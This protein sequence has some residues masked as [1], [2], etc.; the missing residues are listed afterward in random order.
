MITT[1]NQP[2]TLEKMME[3]LR[4]YAPSIAAIVAAQLLSNLFADTSTAKNNRL[5]RNIFSSGPAIP[6]LFILTYVALKDMRDT[7]TAEFKNELQS[8][9]GF[10]KLKDSDNPF[11]VIQIGGNEQTFTNLDRLAA[12]LG[13]MRVVGAPDRASRSF[14]AARRTAILGW[15]DPYLLRTAEFLAVRSVEQSMH[16]LFPGKPP[17]NAR[18]NWVTG[19]TESCN[20]AFKKSGEPKPGAELFNEYLRTEIREIQNIYTLLTEINNLRDQFAH[21]DDAESSDVFRLNLAPFQ[22]ARAC[23]QYRNQGL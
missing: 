11:R 3:Q 19:I 20:I 1:K 23:L 6:A 18:K 21:W 15:A 9:T 14:D 16:E 17:K 7:T 5:L 22:F 13:A 4:K 2:L 8:Y 12:S 10:S